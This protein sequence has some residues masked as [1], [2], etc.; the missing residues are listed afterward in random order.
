[1]GH[2]RHRRLQ[3]QCGFG[4]PEMRNGF[5]SLASR[6]DLWQGQLKSS[7]AEDHLEES[8]EKNPTA[9]HMPNEAKYASNKQATVNMIGQ[10]FMIKLLL[11]I[12][13]LK[14]T[15]ILNVMRN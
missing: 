15:A 12:F 9:I 6:H 3:L 7:R 10:T 13:E 11:V 2:R 8:E 4:Q 1:M 5:P 14:S